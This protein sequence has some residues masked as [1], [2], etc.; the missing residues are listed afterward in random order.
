MVEVAHKHLSKI[1]GAGIY[2]SLQV[3]DLKTSTHSTNFSKLTHLECFNT[4][5][6]LKEKPTSSCLAALFLK[7]HDTMSFF[8]FSDKKKRAL[9]Q[10]SWFEQS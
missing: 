4:L 3:E 7:I 8:F 1:G 9:C 10:V 6:W 2:V 5:F